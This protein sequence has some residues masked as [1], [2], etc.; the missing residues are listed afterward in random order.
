MGLSAEESIRG[1]GEGGLQAEKYGTMFV[2]RMQSFGFNRSPLTMMLAEVLVLCWN[3]LAASLLKYHQSL[4]IWTN[5]SH[6][7]ITIKF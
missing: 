7:G 6:F 4:L 3:T 5:S 2:R 1:E